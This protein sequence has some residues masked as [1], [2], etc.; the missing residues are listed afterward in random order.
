MS[1]TTRPRQLSPS[2]V[3]GGEAFST[4]LLDLPA[5]AKPK[6]SITVLTQIRGGVLVVSGKKSGYA[7]QVDWGDGGKP[8]LL[9]NVGADKTPAQ[10]T[11]VPA[12]HTYAEPK[13]YTVRVWAYDATGNV[14]SDERKITI[15]DAQSVPSPSAPTTNSP[16]VAEDISTSAKSGERVPITLKGTDADGDSLTYSLAARPANGTLTGDAPF[17][18]YKPKEGFS[19]TD[20][21][22]Y[23]ASDGK[24]AS[25]AATV[26]IVVEGLTWVRAGEPLINATNP[27][28]PTEY[29]GGGKTPGYFTEERFAG[30]FTVYRLSETLIAMDDRDV[31]RGKE[32]W[33]ITIESR[34]DAPPP[35]LTPGQVISLTVKF[36]GSASVTEGTPP[37]AIFQY[38]ADKGHGGIIQPADTLSFNTAGPT[39]PDSK[40]WT[41]T[42]PQG[43]P[44][45]TFQVWAGW[46]NCAMCNVTW[47]YKYGAD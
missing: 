29:Y 31:D 38:G 30:K 43:H 20:T 10:G 23:K 45:D 35:L 18:T 14:A 32:F 16:P 37:G 11:S 34:F 39:G 21:F 15:T 27:K 5:T 9:E 47:T 13:T 40:T 2:A 17:L 4:R 24:A 7:L 44:G 6:T 28:A 8:Q 25:P 46:W 42:V 12:S 22:T 33:N 3:Q 1:T 19:G 41:L 36:A 26:R